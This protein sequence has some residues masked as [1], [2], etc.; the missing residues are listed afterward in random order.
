MILI[1][2]SLT[3]NFLRIFKNRLNGFL[4]QNVVNCPEKSETN[5]EGKMAL[6]CILAYTY[7]VEILEYK[8]K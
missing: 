4:G 8:F 5:L 6:H 1:K 3:T 2:S 7:R